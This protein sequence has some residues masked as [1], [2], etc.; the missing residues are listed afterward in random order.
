MTLAQK[1][2]SGQ[3]ITCQSLSECLFHSVCQNAYEFMMKGVM[4]DGEE[5]GLQLI[6][7]YVSET[8]AIEWLRSNL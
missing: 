2:C 3:G 6:P 5:V 7:G 4:P 1:R 8:F